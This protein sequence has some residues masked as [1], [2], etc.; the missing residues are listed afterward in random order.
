[1][2][3]AARDDFAETAT[4]ITRDQVRLRAGFAPGPGGDTAVLLVHGFNA[5]LAKAA[6]RAV[7]AQLAE[8][9]PVVAVELRGHG[10]SQGMCTLGDKEILD[11]QAALR[12]ARTLGFP[13]VVTIGFSMGGAVVVRHAGLI[14]GVAAVVSV[15]GPAFWNYR[16]TSIMR[17]LHFGVENPL[18]RQYLTRVMGTR[19]ISPP[20]PRPWP[21]SPVDAA[22]RIPPVPFLVVHGTQDG[23]FPDEHPRALVRAAQRGARERGVA[24]RTELWLGDFGHA[25]AAIPRDLLGRITDW[26][27][28][29]DRRA[30]G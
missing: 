17:V 5:S 8:R 3:D 29:Q 15:S 30:S 11:V 28:G 21:E 23:F 7:L 6:N 16:G 27:R 14:G 18:A 1:M 9:L 10:R 19:V 13:R 12:W 2:I 22:A 24:D 20:W 26:V 4:L 25:E